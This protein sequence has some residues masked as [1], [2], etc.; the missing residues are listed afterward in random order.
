MIPAADAPDKDHII[1]GKW[2][3]WLNVKED[4]KPAM[5][6]KVD[7]R[8]VEGA[9]CDQLLNSARDADDHPLICINGPP[10]QV[11]AAPNAVRQNGGP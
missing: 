4:G 9:P 5:L 6:V 3:G 2:D 8:A 11:P 7:T 1:D 10:A